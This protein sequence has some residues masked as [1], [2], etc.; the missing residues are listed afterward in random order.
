MHGQ[1]SKIQHSKNAIFDGIPT[2]YPAVQYNSLVVDEQSLSQ[3]L[4][5][6][7]TN[8]KHEVMGLA[9]KGKPFIGVQ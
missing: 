4:E 8:E 9:V 5:V 7:A 1:I 6:I 3:E 2:V